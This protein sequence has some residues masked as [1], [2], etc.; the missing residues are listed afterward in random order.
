MVVQVSTTKQTGRR[1]IQGAWVYVFDR[2]TEG[3]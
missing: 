2:L 1:T 3:G